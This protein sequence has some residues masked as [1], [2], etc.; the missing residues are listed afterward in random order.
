MDEVT[1]LDQKGE[2]LSACPGCRGLFPGTE[3]PPHLYIG[4]SPGCWAVYEEILA[5]EYGEYRYPDV[6]RLTVDTYAVQHPGVTSRQS[7]QSVWV[8]LA[9]LHMV[10]EMGLDSRKA[11]QNIA[12]ILARNPGFEWLEPPARNGLMTVLE[13]REAPNLASHTE[14]VRKWARSVWDAWSPHHALITD[15]LRRS[16]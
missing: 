8:H 6:H 10:L 12:A 2:T 13:V 7:S 14:Q 9:G 15:L 5:K 4:A 1:E 3:G 16:R 11:T